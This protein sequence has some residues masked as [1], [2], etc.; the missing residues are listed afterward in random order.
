MNTNKILGGAALL[1]FSALFM[2]CASSQPPLYYWDGYTNAT[3]R[4]IKGG[5]EEDMAD[6]LS[7]LE[8]CINED[9]A[10]SARQVPPPGICADYAFLLAK[11][12]ENDK[13]IEMLKKEKAIYPESTP[14][15]NAIL[16]KFG[17]DDSELEENTDSVSAENDSESE[18]VLNEE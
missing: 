18:E 4:Y 7:R 15:V 5:N 9:A 12:G 16:K 14:F 17:V 1:A 11:K 8:T 2:S 10:K 13:A 3:Y 6:L